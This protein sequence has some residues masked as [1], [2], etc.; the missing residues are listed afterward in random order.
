MSATAGRTQATLTNARARIVGEREG[1]LADVI[2]GVVRTGSAAGH[3]IAAAGRIGGVVTPLGWSLVALAALA[4]LSGYLFGWVE[5]VAAGWTAVALV[6]TACLSL[7]GRIASDV[8]LRLPA[9]RVVV[10]DRPPV[11]VTVRNPVRRRLH[12]LR[13][14]VSV[15]PGLTEFAAPALAAGEVYSEVFVVP[16]TRRGIVPIGPVRTVRADPAGLLRRELVWADSLDL[17][18]HPRIVAIPSMSTGFVR[19]LEGAPTRDLTAS[20]IAFHALREYLPGDERR[21]IHWKSTAKTGNYMVRQ[22]EETRRSHLLVALS[23][24]AADYASEEEFELAVSATGSLG[25][26]AMLDSRTVSVVASAETPDFAKRM[27]VGARRI[28]TV[29]RGPLLDDLAGVEPTEFALRLPGLA[30]VA[31]ED[32]AGASLVFLLCG[33]TLGAAQLR[34]AAAHFPPG[35]EV[36]AIVCGAGTVPSLRRVA[37]LSILRIG[38]LEDLQRSLAKR[39]AT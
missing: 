3:G 32:T 9:D 5:A 28:S 25:V 39:L 2:V 1:V 38:Y 4:L 34:A 21:T 11:E 16:T 8:S 35:M 26:R 24:S 33:S 7:A 13:L 6:T 22:F 29:G 37:D 15:G 12:G 14:E 18:V 36:V 17:F 20:H 19:D 23:L 31:A 30:Q 27:L 10:G